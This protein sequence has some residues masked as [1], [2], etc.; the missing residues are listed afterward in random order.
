[1]LRKFMVQLILVF[2]SDPITQGDI[3]FPF[4]VSNSPLMA[5]CLGS[6]LIVAA[7]A[8]HLYWMPYSESKLNKLDLLSLACIYVT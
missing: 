4:G 7:G 1:M 5:V 8:Q 6:W 2:V 3:M